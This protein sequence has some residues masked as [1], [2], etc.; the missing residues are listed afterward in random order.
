M[1][2]TR[3]AGPWLL[4]AALMTVAAPGRAESPGLKIE[5]NQWVL[6]NGMKVVFSPMRTAPVVTVQVWYHTGSKDEQPGIRGIAHMFEHMMFKGSQKVRP[7]GHAHMLSS[8]GGSVN[9]FT[10]YDVTAYHNTLPA[11]YM[12]F[13]M[14]LEAER[15][16]ALR[17]TD[18]TITS[19]REVVKE[20]KRVRMDNSPIGRALETVHAMAFTKHPYGWTP[21][22]TIADL[23]AIGKK[24]CQAFYDAHYVPKNATLIV[25]G[26][27]TLAEVRQAAKRQF[28]GT[29]A[30]IRPPR[31]SVVEPP[32]TKL[33]SRDADWPSQLKVV[34]GAY[35]VPGSRHADILALK[36]LSAILSAGQSSRLNQVLV[37]KGKAALGAGGFV[38]G[39]EHP[40]V[41][42][43]YAVG[44]P[45]HDLDKM[46]DLL[47]T[48]VERVASG[49]VTAAELD[50]AK[51]QLSTRMLKGMRSATGLAQA[52][53]MS[54]HLRGDPRA[55]LSDVRRMDK[56]TAADIKRVAATYLKR[57]NLSLILL[58]RTGTAT[59][60]KGGAK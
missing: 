54:A 52:L 59:R 4:A 58:G 31:S 23:N 42:M 16:R 47:L 36:V 5:I 2:I 41:L 34:L 18:E 25:V 12:E 30:G 32:Q 15:M 14:K 20:E 49:G 39:L 43:I 40:G 21:A 27:V 22:G 9:A 19:E 44:L 13:A 26:D 33:R 48:E 53:G 28:G 35:H 56:L 1:Q 10:A 51:N 38:R 24:Q 55:F 37:R 3:R 8:V 45:T 57:D 60:T 17:L 7:E 50:K 46:K 29:A 11:Q 6:K